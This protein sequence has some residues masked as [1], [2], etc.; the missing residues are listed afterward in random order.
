MKK[1]FKRLVTFALLSLT[2]FVIWGCSSLALVPTIVPPFMDDLIEGTTPHITM[3]GQSVTVQGAV[4][5]R[6]KYHDALYPVVKGFYDNL[7]GVSQS[8]ATTILGLA[9]AAG[10][11]GGV[12]AFN[13]VPPGAVKKE[14][15]EAAVLK[16]GLADPEEFKKNVA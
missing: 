7:R 11:G 10:L 9:S 4:D 14:D 5:S 8:I 6:M 3:F 1:F 2:A 13:R 15:H 16:A 12:L